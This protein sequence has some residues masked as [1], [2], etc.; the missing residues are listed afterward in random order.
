VAKAKTQAVA[1]AR[2]GRPARP[3]PGL[4]QLRRLLQARHGD[5]RH[6]PY[7]QNRSS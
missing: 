7:P 6:R 3:W 2:R 1:R 4:R 5:A